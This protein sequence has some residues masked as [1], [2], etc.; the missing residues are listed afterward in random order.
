M[1]STG[2]TSTMVV[3]VLFRVRASSR[4]RRIT[5]A[6]FRKGWKS[7]EHDQRRLGELFHGRERSARI[8]GPVGFAHGSAI[9]Q[10]AKALRDGPCVERL[11]V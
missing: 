7:S 5:A 2:E 1:L 11:A 10:A 6:S 8:R 3:N 4:V 9:V